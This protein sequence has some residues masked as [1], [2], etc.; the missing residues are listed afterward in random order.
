MDQPQH[1]FVMRVLDSAWDLT[2]A[3]IRPDGYPQATTVSFAHEDTVLY[4]GIG[5]D[6]QKAANI[7]ANDKVSLTINLPYKDWREIKGLS[8]SGLAEILD[9]PAE[10]EAARACLERRFPEV[11]VWVGPDMAAEVAF[12]R[13]RPQMVSAID[14]SK[15]FGHTELVTA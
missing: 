14:Y 8:M 13:I 12:L 7:R 2:L 5:R 15:G 4:V 6:S 10:A 1:A 3:T 11:S 9:D